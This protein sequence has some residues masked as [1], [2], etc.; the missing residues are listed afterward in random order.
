MLGSGTVGTLAAKLTEYGGL[1]AGGGGTL[2]GLAGSGALAGLRSEAGSDGLDPASLARMLESQKAAIAG[3]VPNDFAASLKGTGLLGALGERVTPAAAPVPPR[4][5]PVPLPGPKPRW[6]RWLIPLA[7]ALLLA[8]LLPRFFRDEPAPVTPAPPPT[9]ESTA[10]A[11][12]TATPP[13]AEST[14][15]AP[16][17]AT[18]PAQA[19]APADAA[20]DPLVV[21]GV[22]LGATVSGALDSLTE[23]LSGVTDAA[24]AEAALPQLTETRD[25]LAGIEG[26]AAALPEAGRS[27]LSSLVAAG[28]PAIRTAADGLLANTTVGPVL[29]PVLT[30]ILA[31]LDAFAA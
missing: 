23:T 17:T 31:K 7:A 9:A 14:A 4:P 27:A 20:A 25:A 29:Q 3:A 16:E 13:A 2:L 30:D 22:D 8:W 6:T 5:A 26:T 12:Q 28:L 10:P 24:S 15:P 18:P 19:T 11:P 1:P 21:G